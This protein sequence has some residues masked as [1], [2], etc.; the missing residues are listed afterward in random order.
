M[1]IFLEYP[2]CSCVKTV[3]VLR[4]F[5]LDNQ[6]QI[7]L[8][9]FN[10]RVGFTEYP[11]S[12]RIKLRFITIWAAGTRGEHTHP[13]TGRWLIWML[14]CSSEVN[15]WNPPW[16]HWLIAGMQGGERQ[17]KVPT[18][19]SAVNFSSIGKTVAVAT[20]SRCWIS[21]WQLLDLWEL[22]EWMAVTDAVIAV[23]HSKQTF[24]FSAQQC[25]KKTK[26][27]QKQKAQVIETIRSVV[28]PQKSDAA[29]KK[30]FNYGPKFLKYPEKKPCFYSEKC[31]TVQSHFVSSDT[32]VS[33]SM[34]FVHSCLL[35]SP[36][37]SVLANHKKI[38]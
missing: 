32:R 35:I 25:Q 37:C 4:N 3:L 14:Q 6:T 31:S 38:P 34:F 29:A 21:D 23:Q 16:A 8:L 12:T 33:V 20:I 2:I 27:Q 19:S 1:L 13:A 15:E 7:S 24:V 10:Q 17:S 26:Q 28:S 18:S 5:S 11:S 36:E 30:R 22:E 9:R